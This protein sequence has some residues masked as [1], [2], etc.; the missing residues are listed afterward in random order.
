MQTVGLMFGVIAAVVACIAV[1]TTPVAGL[2]IPRTDVAN[3]TDVAFH[4]R[5]RRQGGVGGK[6]T[7]TNGC[8]LACASLASSTI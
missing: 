5:Q 8:A 2:V 7:N 4:S 6:W 1:S 3:L